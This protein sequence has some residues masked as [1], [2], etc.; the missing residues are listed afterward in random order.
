[1]AVTLCH[2]FLV[3]ELYDVEHFAI[4]TVAVTFWRL[5]VIFLVMFIV[6]GQVTNSLLHSQIRPTHAHVYTGMHAH[7]HA[8][9][10]TCTH[11]LVMCTR[12]YTDACMF[13]WHAC[14][15]GSRPFEIP[16]NA[17]VRQCLFTSVPEPVLL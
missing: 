17:H 13:Y 7:K 9:T 15:A 1:M 16:D 4:K 10:H 6:R 8:R 11:V 2:M 12:V 14:F 3:Q 5:P